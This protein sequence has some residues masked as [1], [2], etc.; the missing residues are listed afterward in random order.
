MSIE[1]VFAIDINEMG[2]QTVQR[3][4]HSTHLHPHSADPLICFNYRFITALGV[5]TFQTIH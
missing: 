1:V 3:V 4:A 5:S 2:M